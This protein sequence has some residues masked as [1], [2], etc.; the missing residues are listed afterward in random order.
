MKRLAWYLRQLFPLMYATEYEDPDGIKHVAVWRMWF[1]RCFNS[2]D[3][4]V[5]ETS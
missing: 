1:G 4:I 5:A 3:W 2:R